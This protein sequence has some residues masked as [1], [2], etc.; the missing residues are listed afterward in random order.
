M[1]TMKDVAQRAGVSVATVSH[2]INN[3]RFVSDP[4]RQRVERAMEELDYQP[5]A[6]A[7]SLRRRETHTIGLIVPDNSNPF[8]AEVARGIEDRGFEL[9]YSVILCNSD[10]KVQK[11]LEYLNVLTSKRVDG[12]VFIAATARSQHVESLVNSGIPVVIVDRKMPSVRA[13]AVLVDNFHGGYEAT[14]H[15]LDL[16]HRRIGC[17]AGPSDLTPSADRVAGYRMALE[18]FGVDPDDDLVVRGDYYASSGERAV[19]RFLELDR[20]PTAIFAC[21]DLMAIAA[22]KTL[23][24]NGLRVPQDVAVVGFDDIALAS[25]VNPPLTTVAQPKYEMGTITVDVLLQ[26]VKGEGPEERQEILLEC[27]LVVRESTAWQEVMLMQ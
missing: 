12:I 1:A 14:R 8:F 11:E 19:W 4:L 23:V 17:I 22:M 5:D 15:L 21:N 9:G 10:S 24:D 26:R 6:V 3:T 18:E 27:Q 20:P 16:G 25:Y 7:R 13:D 2:V